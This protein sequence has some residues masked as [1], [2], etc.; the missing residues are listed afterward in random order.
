MLRVLLFSAVLMLTAACGREADIAPT[1]ARVLA[2]PVPA[3]QMDGRALD[4]PA[5][6]DIMQRN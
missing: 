5:R 4:L 1:L 2:I 6:N 3:G